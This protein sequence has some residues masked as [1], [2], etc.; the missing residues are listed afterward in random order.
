[1]NLRMSRNSRL[2]TRSASKRLPPIDRKFSLAAVSLYKLQALRVTWIMKRSAAKQWNSHQRAPV[3]ILEAETYHQ[4]Q[5]LSKFSKI[6][7]FDP[8]CGTAFRLPCKF[9]CSDF[10]IRESTWTFSSGKKYSYSKW[11]YKFQ[12]NQNWTP[13]FYQNDCRPS[14]ASYPSP[15]YYSTS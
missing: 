7:I 8:T 5:V 4:R 10:L 13:K 1:M 15:R 14:T 6:K 11:I 12:E 2:N 3:R 9:I